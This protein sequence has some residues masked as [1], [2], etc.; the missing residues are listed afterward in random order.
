MGLRCGLMSQLTEEEE[1]IIRKHLNV[2]YQ[3][4]ITQIGVRLKEKCKLA[5]GSLNIKIVDFYFYLDLF[6]L[7]NLKRF[8]PSIL[9]DLQQTQKNVV[10]F[11]FN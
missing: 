2:P 7:L 10:I 6:Y 8:F 3:R 4:R 1:T 5:C 11:E 9:E